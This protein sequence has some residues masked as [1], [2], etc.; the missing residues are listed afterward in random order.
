M[1]RS[2]I[3]RRLS[4]FTINLPP[5]TIGAFFNCTKPLISQ[6]LYEQHIHGRR[7]NERINVNHKTSLHKRESF[8]A[9]I[10]ADKLKEILDQPLGWANY[11]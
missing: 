2:D 1:G 4:T 7:Q 5:G 3:F 11:V 10:S 8:M 9:V 6:A